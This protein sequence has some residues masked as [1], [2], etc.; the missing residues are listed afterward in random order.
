MES[1]HYKVGDRIR[2][3]PT[4]EMILMREGAF[5]KKITGLK[6]GRTYVVSRVD[7]RAVE[8][9]GVTVEGGGWNLFGFGLIRHAVQPTTRPVR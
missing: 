6:E 1:I 2:L 5:G 3:N 4:V 9:E 8:L 7:S